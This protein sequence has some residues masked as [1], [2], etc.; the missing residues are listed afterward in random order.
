MTQIGVANRKSFGPKVVGAIVASLT[1]LASGSAVGTPML[2]NLSNV[3]FNDGGMAS[4][5][6]MYD[7]DTNV[8]SGVSITT[9]GG[10][11]LPGTTYDTGEVVNFPFPT[12]NLHL[13]LIDNLG[14]TDLLWQTLIGLTYATA[15]TNAGGAINLVP[16]FFSSFEGICGVANCASDSVKR[17]NT[18]ITGGRV[19]AA[20]PE[21]ATTTRTGRRVVAAVPEP[22]TLALLGLGLAGL[23]FSRRKQ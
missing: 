6:F 14:L 10:S 15:L 5:S 16:D 8:Y 23:G 7:A 19:V 12:N 13:T 22:A 21:P 17:P 11:T 20:A 2:W 1:V 9:S 4:G 18:T 3:V